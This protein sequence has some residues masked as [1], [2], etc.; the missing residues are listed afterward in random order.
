[1]E[2]PLLHDS[3]VPSIIRNTLFA[4]EALKFDTQKPSKSHDITKLQSYHRV[5]PNSQITKT[6]F[7]LID[8]SLSQYGAKREA[9]RQL[10]LRKTYMYKCALISYR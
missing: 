6:V 5:S 9:K 2:L 3:R 7:K 8:F 10:N 4:C 1:M